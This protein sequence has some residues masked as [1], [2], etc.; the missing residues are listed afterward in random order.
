[1]WKGYTI[2]GELVIASIQLG[3]MCVCINVWESCVLISHHT[4][5]HHR[6]ILY[7]QIS[8]HSF[9]FSLSFSFARTANEPDWLTGLFV[10]IAHDILFLLC[11]C[12]VVRSI[13]RL[14]LLFAIVLYLRLWSFSSGHIFRASIMRRANAMRI[15]LVLDVFILD[16]RWWCATTAA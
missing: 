2:N 6:S 5:T 1:M 3:D 10:C 13:V 16:A 7:V 4:T 12:F 11:V 15:T 9:V 8:R 14:R